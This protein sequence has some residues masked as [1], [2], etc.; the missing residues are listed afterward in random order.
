M[1]SYLLNCT[2]LISER[3]WHSVLP[4]AATLLQ[5]FNFLII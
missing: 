2:K 1:V 4:L 5:I 3:V